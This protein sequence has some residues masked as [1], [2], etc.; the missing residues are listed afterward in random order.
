[1]LEVFSIYF[2]TAS[3]CL[4][5]SRRL[6]EHGMPVYSS[7]LGDRIAQACLDTYDKLGPKG[8]PRLRQD[9]V[10]EWSVLAGFVLLDTNTDQVEVLSLG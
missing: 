5:T 7:V 2:A 8:K 4:L 10:R 9:G 6:P 3:T 1:M